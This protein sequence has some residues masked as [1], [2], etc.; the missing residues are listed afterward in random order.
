M[1]TAVTGC[2]VGEGLGSGGKSELS[3]NSRMEPGEVARKPGLTWQQAG[4]VRSGGMSGGLAGHGKRTA[5]R[6]ETG[7]L[8]LPCP[9]N[10]WRG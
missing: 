5:L 3:S 2:G 1:K 6:S 7:N 10:Q 8:A 9:Q 4:T